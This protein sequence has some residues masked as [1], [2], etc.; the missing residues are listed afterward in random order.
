MTRGQRVRQ[1]KGLARAEAVMDQMERKV[2]DAKTKLKKRNM[3]KALWE[4]VNDATADEKRKA[5]KG[6]GRGIVLGEDSHEPV[7]EDAQMNSTESS[8]PTTDATTTAK[9]STMI[10]DV[11]TAVD[12][13][14]DEEIDLIT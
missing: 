9:P 10:Q 11:V 1:E 12:S 2:D 4:E 7:E 6:P 8:A 5:M 13:K 3:R 14:Q